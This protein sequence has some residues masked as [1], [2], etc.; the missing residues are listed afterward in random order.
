MVSIPASAIVNVLPN[1]ITAG[2]SGLDLVGLILTSSARLPVNTV[3]NFSTVEDVASYFG[4]LSTEATLAGNYFGGFDGSTI[5]PAIL[6]F[7][8][9]S[10][11]AVASF[12]RGGALGLTLAQVQALSGTLTISVNGT[13][14]TSS[15]INLSTATSLSNAASIIQA[16]FTS[17]GFTVAYDSIADAFVFT[18]ATTGAASSLSFATGTLADG[19]K[20]T[21]ANGAVL[22]AGADAMVPGTAMNSVVAATQDFVSFMTAQKPTSDAVMLGFAEWADGKNNRYLY[23]AFDDNPAATQSGNTTAF[24]PVVKASGYS[25]VAPLYDPNNGAAIAAFVM[26]AIAS[27]DFGA[28]NGRTTYAFRSQS[29]LNAG[30]VNQTIADNLIANGYNFYGAY[31]TANDQFV[32]LYPGQVSGQ[33]EWLDSWVNQVWLNNAIQL[34]Q[35]SLLT[36]IGSVPYNDEGRALIEAGM[37]DPINA[38]VNFGAIRAGVVLSAAQRAEINNAAGA[39]VA[40]VV[41]QRGWYVKVGVAAPQVRAARASPPVYLWYT[42]GQSVQRLTINSV[43][44]Q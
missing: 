6:R 13:A 35:M 10:E 44:V 11:T 19:L 22:S 34:A 5:K 18:N 26:G 16:A 30:V 2:G 27:T 39:Q 12:L 21:A 8:R 41:E 25:S 4:P 23:V 43:L 32:F 31:A 37:A 7:F 38:A 36:G 42:D 9:F 29:G 17:P 33:F 24:G 3:A 14:K 1:V 28:F 20:L 15:S 40:D